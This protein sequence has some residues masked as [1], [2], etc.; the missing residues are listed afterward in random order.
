MRKGGW[1]RKN[2]GNPCGGT[3]TKRPGKR[4]PVACT[5]SKATKTIAILKGGRVGGGLDK[6]ASRGKRDK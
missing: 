3:E 2:V 1:G 6:R 5:I 4:T